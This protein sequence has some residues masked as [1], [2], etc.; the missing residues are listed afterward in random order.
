MDTMRDRLELHLRDGTPVIVRPLITEDREMVAE[1]Y[2]RLTPEARYLRFWT[3]TGEVIG[4]EMLER[5][6]Q[7]DAADHLTW[8]VLD[9]VR[10]FPGTGGASWWREAGD[11]SQAEISLMVFDDDQGRGIGTLLLAVAWISAFR[12]GIGRLVGYCLADNRR[13]ANWM[14]DCG[15]SGVWDGYKLVFTWDLTNPAA[16]PDT[17]A[18]ADLA[19]WLADLSPCLLE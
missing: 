11:P 14:R 13:A 2:R 1:A 3:R 6:V 7:Q 5:L 8:V 4:R 12:A 9:P 10:D 17:P 15:A 19:A 16:L 18:A